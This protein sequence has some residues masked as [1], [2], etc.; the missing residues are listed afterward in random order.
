MSN[1][2]KFKLIAIVAL[3]ALCAAGQESRSAQNDDKGLPPMPVVYE[4]HIVP[5][6]PPTVVLGEKGKPGVRSYKPGDKFGDL[7]ITGITPDVLILTYQGK[8]FERKI[9]DLKSKTPPPTA[10]ASHAA[11]VAQ[12]RAAET[13]NGPGA[14][15]SSIERACRNGDTTPAG[16]VVNGYRKQIAETPMG[17]SCSWIKEDK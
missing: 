10:P 8:T 2:A 5:R 17:S 9:A 11:P 13:G 3:S 4:V 7:Y 12:Q 6:R 14:Q 1:T 16:T 15:I